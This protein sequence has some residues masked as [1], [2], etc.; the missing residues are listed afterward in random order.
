[1]LSTLLSLALTLALA[2]S[3]DVAAAAPD[4]VVYLAGAAALA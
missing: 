4:K 1:M 3:M 2:L